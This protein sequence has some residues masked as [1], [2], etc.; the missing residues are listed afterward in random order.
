MI[1]RDL[2]LQLSKLDLDM[3]AYFQAPDGTAVYQVDEVKEMPILVGED[4]DEV[5]AVVFL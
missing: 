3:P 5:Q 2:M 4:E 1:I